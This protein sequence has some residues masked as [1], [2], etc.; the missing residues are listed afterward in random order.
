MEIKYHNKFIYHAINI[1]NKKKKYF[2]LN[3][4]KNLKQIVSNYRLLVRNTNLTFI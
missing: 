2:F 3:D 1:F 4:L